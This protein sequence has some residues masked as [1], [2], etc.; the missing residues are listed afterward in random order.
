MDVK[1]FSTEK[2]RNK[3][4]IIKLVADEV[5]DTI[6][7][8]GVLFL[9]GMFEYMALTRPD[10]SHETITRTALITIVTNLF[11]FRFTKSSVKNNGGQFR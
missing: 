7:I 11:T 10:L 9:W 8:A 4:E 6:M 3:I 1:T 5:Q 2:A